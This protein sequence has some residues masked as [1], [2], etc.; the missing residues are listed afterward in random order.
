MKPISSTMAEFVTPGNSVGFGTEQYLMP[1]P[2]P[3]SGMALFDEPNFVSL[4]IRLKAADSQLKSALLLLN[5]E[6]MQE[7][8]GCSTW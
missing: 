1:S 3:I 4:Q 7:R 8:R 2:D 6:C 5:R